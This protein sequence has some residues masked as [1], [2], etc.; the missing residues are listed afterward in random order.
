MAAVAKF[1]HDRFEDH[2]EIEGSS[3]RGF[4]LTV[5]GILI[6]IGLVR[7]AFFEAGLTSTI[8]FMLPGALLVVFAVLRPIL[9]APLNKFWMKL[10]LLLASIVNPIVM[11]L[12]YLLL[13][14]PIGLGM[15]LFGRDALRMKRPSDASTHWIER[16]PAGPP[17]E[18]MKN[19][20]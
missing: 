2:Q 11:G 3:D 18:T 9:L 4:G 10:G 17:P 14:V 6:A 7:W 16:D 5:G 1:A 19:Q 13:F 20:F 12:M 15:K 8:A